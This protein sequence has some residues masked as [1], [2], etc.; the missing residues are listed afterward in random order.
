MKNYH[1]KPSFPDLQYEENAFLSTSSHE[2]RSITEWNIDGLVEHQVYNKLHEMGVAI[3]AY[4]MRGSSDTD[5]ANMIIAGFTGMLKHWWDNYCTDEV[6]HLIITATANETVVKMEGNTQ[7]TSTQT[8]EDACATLLYHIAKHFIGEPKLFQDRSLQILSNLSCPNLDNF[9]H[10]RHAFLSKVM[11]RPDCNLD[12][13]KERFISGLPPLFADK[14]RTKIQDR[15]NGS[16]PYNN[17]TY[18]DLVSTINIVALELR[19]DIK[20]RHQLKKEQSSSR[21]ELGSFCR[22]FGFIT[23]PDTKKKEER[24]KSYRKKSTRK[25]DSSKSS[26]SKRKK[27]RSKRSTQKK[28]DVCWNCGKRGHRANECRSKTK[29]K[30]INLLDMDKETKGKLLAI[31][32]EPFS[33]ITDESKENN[34]DEDINLD[35]D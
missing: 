35:Y 31:L 11:I 30:K 6:K 25:D 8:R 21:K 19:T 17:L 2:G 7:T 34:S 33:D 24:E 29:K 14:V 20:L 5:A 10:Y 15:N 18:G 28:Q 27:T 4:K 22:D 16:I 3:T 9:I 26:K 32:D 1:S 12:Y 23:P 13:W